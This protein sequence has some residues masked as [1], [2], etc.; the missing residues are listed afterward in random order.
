[1]DNKKRDSEALKEISGPVLAEKGG[2]AMSFNGQIIL[3]C[4]GQAQIFTVRLIMYS[5]ISSSLNV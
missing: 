1:M 3:S 5:R 4:I 2:P